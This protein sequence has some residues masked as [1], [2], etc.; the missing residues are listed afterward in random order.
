MA[1]HNTFS[2]PPCYPAPPPNMGGHYWHPYSASGSTWRPQAMPRWSAPYYNYD[3]S[4]YGSPWTQQ[5]SQ[6]Y[7]ETP[8]KPPTFVDTRYV[9]QAD[10]NT[11][12]PDSTQ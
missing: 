8:P 7:C 3:W 6:Y 9:Q 10:Y 5:D 11:P 2:G 1:P 12:P 4:S